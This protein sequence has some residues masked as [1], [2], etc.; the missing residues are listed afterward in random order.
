MSQTITCIA[1]FPRNHVFGQ[2][3]IF[4]DSGYDIGIALGK[5]IFFNAK[6][7]LCFMFLVQDEHFT[8][9]ALYLIKTLR[10]MDAN[11]VNRPFS[12]DF[13]TIRRWIKKLFNIFDIPLNRSTR[14]L[15]QFPR[16]TGGG[17]R[18]R[19]RTRWLFRFCLECLL[20][21]E[22]AFQ[23]LSLTYATIIIIKGYPYRLFD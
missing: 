4:K 20:F 3:C 14:R 19:F 7:A 9:Q 17:L 21:S 1:V 18:F 16:S 15:L 8:I 23:F 5:L 2:H 12:T 6:G 11:D 22:P 13:R 10:T